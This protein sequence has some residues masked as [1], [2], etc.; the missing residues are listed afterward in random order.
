MEYIILALIIL[1]VLFNIYAVFTAG[2]EIHYH[3]NYKV[4]EEQEVPPAARK[5]GRPKGSK[6]KSKTK[7]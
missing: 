7:N 3:V 2:D 4:K 6:N 5:R 1:G